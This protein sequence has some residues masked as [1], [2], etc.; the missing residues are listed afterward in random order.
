MADSKDGDKCSHSF[1]S[2][3]P[4]AISS[5]HSGYCTEPKYY[6]FVYKSNYN[7][8]ERGRIH[9]M[10]NAESR[11]SAERKSHHSSCSSLDTLRNLH[12]ARVQK[13]KYASTTCLLTIGRNSGS[14]L[15]DRKWS[16]KVSLASSM[17]AVT[18]SMSSGFLDKTW[19]SK[20]ASSLS[21]STLARSFS[22]KTINEDIEGF[23]A[24]YANSSSEQG[25]GTFES[26]G[27]FSTDVMDMN[28]TSSDVGFETDSGD[29]TRMVLSTNVPTYDMNLLTP[30]KKSMSLIEKPIESSSID[31]LC[32]EDFDKDI[33]Q[34]ENMFDNDSENGDQE[35][36]E[37]RDQTQSFLK[38]AFIMN[39]EL[40]GSELKPKKDENATANATVTEAT[41][42]A[43]GQLDNISGA[44]FVEDLGMDTSS[45]SVGRSPTC[46]Y[47]SI[48]SLQQQSIHDVD[49]EILTSDDNLCPCEP[50]TKTVKERNRRR[51][52]IRTNGIFNMPRTSNIKKKTKIV[53]KRSERVSTI[54][55]GITTRSPTKH[56]RSYIVLRQQSRYSDHERHTA[57]TTQDEQDSASGTDCKI[58]KKQRKPS[59]KLRKTRARAS[60]ETVEDSEIYQ[61][62]EIEK[63]QRVERNA[64]E[65][66]DESEAKIDF[67]IETAMVPG[68]VRISI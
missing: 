52:A 54:V 61:V 15:G 3:S 64:D 1:D 12:P 6:S 59:V 46:E 45:C 10:F 11:L 42:N 8:K 36:L 63:E 16:S 24:C 65:T 2:F 21:I 56:M 7:L 66:L 48:E 30:S 60:A 18:H 14:R 55:T 31:N 40:F 29:L 53:K 49:T 41:E 32:M 67:G 26:S 25:Y 28:I 34:I 58:G 19:S 51:S 23:P 13:S 37:L 50:M 5:P 47:A 27:A 44:S 38:E 35:L 39:M 57:L 20:Y 43:P 68:K 22:T 4:D 62:E 33:E 17:K 9:L